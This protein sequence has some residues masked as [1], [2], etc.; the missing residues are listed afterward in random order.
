MLARI[1]ANSMLTL[2]LDAGDYGPGAT[3]RIG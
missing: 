1:G 3:K 2:A